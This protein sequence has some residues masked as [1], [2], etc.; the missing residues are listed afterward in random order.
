MTRKC[1]A[2]GIMETEAKTPIQNGHRI[3]V[4]KCRYYS[5]ANQD[6]IEILR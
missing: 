3:F 5:G 1:H 6:W 2:R 4:K